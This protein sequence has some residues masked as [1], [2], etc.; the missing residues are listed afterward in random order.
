M[1][2]LTMDGVVTLAQESRFQLTDENGIAHLFVLA[3]A[4]LAEP[5][6]LG[7]L[8][9]RQAKVRV[10]YDQAS[11][12]IANVAHKVQLREADASRPTSREGRA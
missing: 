10:T 8:Q 3:H 9:K 5:A 6:Q 1:R 7:Q 2:K 11:N 12:L 4:A